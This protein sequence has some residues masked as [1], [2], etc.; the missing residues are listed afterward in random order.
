MAET[1]YDENIGGKSGNFHIALG[2]GLKENYSGNIRTVKNSYLEKIG[3]NLN[4]AIHTDIIST[5]DKTVTATLESG[6][7]KVVYE[8][9]KF[10]ECG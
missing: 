8:K 4:C 7:K 3:F 2:R 6:E 5:E 10:V 9:G 1:L